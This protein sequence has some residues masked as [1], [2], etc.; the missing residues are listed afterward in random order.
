MSLRVSGMGSPLSS[1]TA[2]SLARGSRDIVPKTPL[3]SIWSLWLANCSSETVA[4]KESS[5]TRFG[6]AW[7]GCSKVVL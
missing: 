3:S 4:N 2:T 6:C 7:K 5:A 1:F